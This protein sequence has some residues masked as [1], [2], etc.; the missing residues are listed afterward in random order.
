MTF[1][2]T[3]QAMRRMADVIE[4]V[5]QK[6]GRDTQTSTFKP[7]FEPESAVGAASM[8]CYLRDLVTV[9][10]KEMYDRGTLLVL[11]ETISRDPEL[12]PC[13]AGQLL[14]QANTEDLDEE[15]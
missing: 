4:N 12:F 6:E 8:L 1:L 13:G 9:G 10:D 14:W 15:N 3:A 5:V 7:V 2:E 11:L